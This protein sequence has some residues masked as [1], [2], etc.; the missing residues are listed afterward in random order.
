VHCAMARGRN[1]IPQD[2]GFDYN[3]EEFGGV[4]KAA[5]KDSEAAR[6]KRL[7][8]EK[9]ATRIP[10]SNTP[11]PHP[12]DGPL[13]Y[14]LSPFDQLLP[15]RREE[16]KALKMQR[17]WA[18]RMSAEYDQLPD[19]KLS[20]I[21]NKAYDS[22][23]Y[24]HYNQ[25][26]KREK[27]YPQVTPWEPQFDYMRWRETFGMR[28]TV[29]GKCT[30][31]EL[32]DFLEAG[33]VGRLMHYDEGRTVIVELCSPG[34]EL[35][36]P[37]IKDRY[38]CKVPGDVHWDLT[39]LAY[40]NRNGEI[41]RTEPELSRT[42][43]SQF[44][45]IDATTE[46]FQHLWPYTVPM[47]VM[48]LVAGML[49]MD[50]EVEA[51]RKM[52]KRPR[53]KPVNFRD[54]AAF[55]FVNKYLFRGRLSRKAPKKDMMDEFGKSKAKM[56]NGPESGE[57]KKKSG[58]LTREEEEEG[59]YDGV[60]FKDVA[61]LDSI[62]DEFRFIIGVMQ[63]FKT[64][65]EK[66]KLEKRKWKLPGSGPKKKK[67]SWLPTLATK[68]EAPKR[69][70]QSYFQDILAG[71]LPPIGSKEFLNDGKF[72]V[73]PMNWEQRELEEKEFQ[74]ATMEY[75]KSETWREKARKMETVQEEEEADSGMEASRAR[76]SIPKG[77]LFE[78]PPGTGKTLLAKAVAGEA[79]V[80]FFYANGSEFVEM[81]VGVAAK[82]VRDLF[83][84]ARQVAPSII[85]IDELDTI[86]R[87]R[88]LY[89]SRDSA[90]LEREA[91]LMQLLVEL[92]GFE[93][94]SI[95]GEEQEMVLVMGATNLST[96]LD[97]ALLRSGRFERSFYIG[98]PKTSLDRLAILK[99]HTRKLNFPRTGDAKFSEDAVL[100][101]AAELTDGYSGAALS[102]LV[103]EAAI[104]SVR[105]DRDMVTL[106]DV[107]RVIERN[108]VGFTLAPLEVGWGKD[109]RAMLE[110]GRAV[111]WSS[112][113]SMAYCPEVLR[114]T[115]KPFAN[116]MTGVMCT[117]EPRDNKGTPSVNITGEVRADTLDDFIDGMA[118]LLAGR[119]VET[120]FFGPQG[121]S[122]Q[123]KADLVAAAD[124]AYD[125]VTQSGMYPDTKSIRP[126][127]PE[128]LI[129]HFALPRAEM[130]AGVV[131]LMIRAHIRSEEYINFYKPVILQVASE[132]L[133][134][135][136]LYGT[137]V[138]TLVDEHD[139][140]MRIAKDV[141][142]AAVAE[143]AKADAHMAK[144][145]A[146]REE[147]D[148]ATRR[149]VRAGLAAKWAVKKEAEAAAK[150]KAKAE[151][152]EA[153]AAAKAKQEEDQGIAGAIDVDS[154]SGP[155]SSDPF[156]T[157]AA[158][159][160]AAAAEV[161][162]V[163][164]AEYRSM[165]S[166]ALR[167]I[168]TFPKPTET[169]AAAA[170]VAAPLTASVDEVAA[171]EGDDKEV[172]PMTFNFGAAAAV[173]EAREDDDD[174]DDSNDDY[175]DALSRALRV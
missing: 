167:T 172:A 38:E 57:K 111:L 110:A 92:D 8:K 95:A 165:L 120:V 51:Y 122:V 6:L 100:N 36:G 121:V 30:Y 94:K 20:K 148:R 10:L 41:N 35:G 14:I 168:G 126:L 135:G 45:H 31:P 115:I 13:P 84:R 58:K 53:K 63:D 69:K 154:S 125:I 132:L 129:E 43:L 106:G 133:A 81:F 61:G 107:E 22:M 3:D 18:R 12:A 77:V 25:I 88:A 163:D 96:Q 59:T 104:L 134:H 56:L 160:T 75:H 98:V 114:V 156:G 97:P 141:E 23:M 136:S 65:Q 102:A 86:G 33:E 166:R 16:A 28:P 159:A 152:A 76:L 40:F 90:T 49:N 5:P 145:E 34:F 82:R 70:Q 42:Q 68:K 118:M 112:K 1:N 143:K 44:M 164:A 175:K 19:R 171:V 15:K 150:A 85:F 158:A 39:K 117:P 80:P 83:K 7:D 87:S 2:V 99:V 73:R 170:A 46:T 162:E 161:A 52:N 131:D 50:D 155:L 48:W 173:V 130:N 67:S 79:G 169:A 78:G 54:F 138:R 108:L 147:E 153:A 32:M 140:R 9:L 101:R 26:L 116:R 89:G 29:K 149:A 123:T 64:M 71:N 55:A 174:D 24:E 151:V 37:N 17:A 109:H 93:T 113:A 72:N 91:G 4:A 103:N 124:V 27:T 119:C 21:S 105:A 11:P 137:H 66:A 142:L 128:A 62:V 127:W 74:R 60:T 139:I 146:L 144:E 47:I 157:A